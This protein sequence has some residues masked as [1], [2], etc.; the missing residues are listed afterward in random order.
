MALSSWICSLGLTL[1]LLLS[2]AFH[3]SQSVNIGRQMIGS[4]P[5][6]CVNKCMNCEPCKA[7][8]VTQ[9]NRDA[10]KRDADDNYYL[11]SWKCTCRDHLFQP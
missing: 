4:R 10:S 11:L 1:A 8:L 9:K 3:P 5:P 7:S 2:L 6:G